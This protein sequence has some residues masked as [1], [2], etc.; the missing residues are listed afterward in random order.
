M[1][2]LMVRH[3]TWFTTVGTQYLARTRCTL[4]APC[5]PTSAPCYIRSWRKRTRARAAIGNI[6][7][8][9]SN[10]GDRMVIGACRRVIAADRIGWRKH[11]DPADL[12]L[13]YSF[14]TEV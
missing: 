14:Y 10:E 4:L 5:F 7:R 6:G 13:V 12:E 2:S 3:L 9:A 11:A 1:I 8:A